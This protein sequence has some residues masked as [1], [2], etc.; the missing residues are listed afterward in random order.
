MEKDY[1]IL[2][3]NYWKSLAA[4]RWLACVFK[5]CSLL[6]FIEYI[7]LCFFFWLLLVV[8]FNEQKTEM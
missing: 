4:Q 7:L 6:K 1:I 5:K 3:S 8:V 2:D